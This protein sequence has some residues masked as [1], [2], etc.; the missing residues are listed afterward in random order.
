LSSW[1]VISY[2]CARCWGLKCVLRAHSCAACNKACMLLRGA[3]MCT[4][5]TTHWVLQPTPL[6]TASWVQYLPLLNTLQ[7]RIQQ[8]PLLNTLPYLPHV[9]VWFRCGHITCHCAVPTGLQITAA[10][11]GRAVV[12]LGAVSG[13]NAWG[14]AVS[15]D[16]WALLFTWRCPGLVPTCMASNTNFPCHT[17]HSPDPGIHLQGCWRA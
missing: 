1:P 4:P 6:H 5:P 2:G 17:A 15:G 3:G 8:L 13:I 12:R 9:L 7:P 11:G 16:K 10:V 14:C